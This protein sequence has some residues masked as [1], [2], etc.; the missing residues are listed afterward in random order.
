MSTLMDDCLSL[1]VA[2]F[3]V[4]FPPVSARAPGV[5]LSERTVYTTEYSQQLH[6]YQ[7]APALGQ[8]PSLQLPFHAQQSPILPPSQYA[9][10]TPTKLTPFQYGAGGSNTPQQQY[11][12]QKQLAQQYSM[13][14][15]SFQQSSQVC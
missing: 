13:A 10:S 8:S 14:R 5:V 4:I 9:T 3:V 12:L 6:Q 7:P 2:N 1:T 15:P 11:E